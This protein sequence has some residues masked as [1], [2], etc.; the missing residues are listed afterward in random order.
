ML[1]FAADGVTTLFVHMT[2][3]FGNLPEADQTIEQSLGF[4]QYS[5]F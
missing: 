3:V 1:P 5:D 4:P 2:L